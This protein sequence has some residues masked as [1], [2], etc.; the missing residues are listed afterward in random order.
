[1]ITIQ[2]EA[3]YIDIDFSWRYIG[4]SL[5]LSGLTQHHLFELLLLSI[6]T[7]DSSHWCFCWTIGQILDRLKLHLALHHHSF[8]L[9]T[10]C[11]LR[12]WSNCNSLQRLLDL[13]HIGIFIWYF[14][15]IATIKILLLDC[16]HLR[17]GISIGLCEYLLS[18]LS[19][20]FS[21][22]GLLAIGVNHIHVPISSQFL[23]VQRVSKCALSHRLL[24]IRCIHSVEIDDFVKVLLRDILAILIDIIVLKVIFHL[25]CSSCTW[26]WLFSWVVVLSNS[27]FG[28]FTLKELFLFEDVGLLVIFGV[29][30]SCWF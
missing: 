29:S 23:G 6:Q 27:V 14:K 13:F 8:I 4:R 21:S 7:C 15:F 17:H 2:V 3:L 9:H 5:L 30:L 19:I 18:Y 25:A 24:R 12:K 20:L 11:T 16:L 10:M 22:I 1:M 26:D 28:T